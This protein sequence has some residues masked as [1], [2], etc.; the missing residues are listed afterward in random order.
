LLIFQEF[1]WLTDLSLST[2]LMTHAVHQGGSFF[3]LQLE[4][5]TIH[6]APELFAEIRDANAQFVL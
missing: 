3:D 5:W 4:R 1:G 2:L 6:L